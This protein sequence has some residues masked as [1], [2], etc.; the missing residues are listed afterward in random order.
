MVLSDV[1]T[2]PGKSIVEFLGLVQGNTIR[3][4]HVGREALLRL[5]EGADELGAT[6]VLNV[7]YETSSIAALGMIAAEI[8]ACGTAIRSE[9]SVIEHGNIDGLIFS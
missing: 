3:A 6:H 5:L 7:R 9:T 1:E 8:H 2:V 4:K